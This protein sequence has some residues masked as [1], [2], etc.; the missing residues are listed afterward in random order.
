MDTVIAYG[1]DGIKSMLGN[2]VEIRFLKGFATACGK[3]PLFDGA[4]SAVRPGRSVARAVLG[5]TLAEKLF[6]SGEATHR[7][8]ASTVNGGLDSG[9]DSANRAAEYINLN[10]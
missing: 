4:Y 1:L 10:S 6:F 5:R 3:I 9:R 8:Q 7:T 2:D